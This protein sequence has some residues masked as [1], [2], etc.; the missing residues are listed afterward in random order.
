MNV[1]GTWAIE[2]RRRL[3]ECFWG[4]EILHF[5]EVEDCLKVQRN[6]PKAVIY[7]S[8]TTQFTAKSIS[9]IYKLTFL[10]KKHMITYADA[11]PDV[12]R[13]QNIIKYCTRLTVPALE[14]KVDSPQC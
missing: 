3:P 11:R 12:P 2:P 8:Y 10:D 5:Y 7:F 6:P 13:C 1:Y 4:L 9:F 14:N